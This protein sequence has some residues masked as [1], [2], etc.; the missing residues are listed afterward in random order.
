MTMLD[1]TR[2]TFALAYHETGN[3]SEAL[4][5]AKPAQTKRWKAKTVHETASRYLN[6]GKVLARLQELQAQAREKHGVTIESL[7]IELQ[8]A[9]A[10]ALANQQANAAVSATM[11]KAKLHGLLIDKAEVTGKDGGALVP[12]LKINLSAPKP[13]DDER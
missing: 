3:A 2:E 11:G 4:R 10:L 13:R 7:T 8:E 12:V 6:D 1:Q 9:R 5:K